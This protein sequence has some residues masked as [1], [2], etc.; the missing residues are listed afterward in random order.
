MFEQ[1]LLEQ[2]PKVFYEILIAHPKI[3][4]VDLTGFIVFRMERSDNSKIFFTTLD[5][6]SVNDLPDKAFKYRVS[7]GGFDNKTQL[8]LLKDTFFLAVVDIDIYREGLVE[9][10]VALLKEINLEPS[11]ILK[12]DKGLHIVYLSQTLLISEEELNVY[13]LYSAC[14]KFK[15][16]LKTFLGDIVPIDKVMIVDGYYTRLD[17]EVVYEGYLYENFYDWYFRFHIEREVEID[18]EEEK[19]IKPQELTETFN[20]NNLLKGSSFITNPFLPLYDVRYILNYVKFNCPTL[21]YILNNFENHT[22]YEWK[23]AIWF[24]YFLYKYIANEDEKKVLLND[25][26]N[27]ASLYRKHPP[28]KSIKY[29]QKFFEWFVMRDFP[30]LFWSCNK[31]HEVF[32]CGDCPHKGLRRLPFIPDFYLPENVIYI[33]DR[34][35]A[36]HHDK[37][38][39]SY[40]VYICQFF[41][42]L[43][44]VL[45]PYGSKEVK[46]KIITFFNKQKVELIVSPD[47]T[48]GLKEADKF[49]ISE[50]KKF[51]ELIRY[52]NSNLL[53]VM[54]QDLIGVYPTGA[55]HKYISIEDFALFTSEEHEFGNLVVE[56][57]GSYDKFEQALLTLLYDFSDE[58]YFQ[59]KIAVLLGLFS[60]F[61][62]RYYKL[63]SLNP[64]F[65]WFGTSGVGKTTCAKIV[66]A[67]FREP[68][69]MYEAGL[70]NITEAWMNR[71]APL[72]RAPLFVDDIKVQSITEFRTLFNR[73][74]QLANRNLTKLNVQFT[75]SGN[76]Y[77][78][79]FFTSELRFVYRFVATDGLNRRFFFINMGFKHLKLQDI[80]RRIAEEIISVLE[81]N[82]GHGFTFYEKFIMPY[83]NQILAFI[84]KSSNRFYEIFDIGVHNK[85]LKCLEALARIVFKD[86]EKAEG[87]IFRFFRTLINKPFK[88]LTSND[89]VGLLSLAE[90]YPYI[91]DNIFDEELILTF[92]KDFSEIRNFAEHIAIFYEILDN[93]SKICHELNLFYNLLFANVFISNNELRFMYPD[94]YYNFFYQVL[95]ENKSPEILIEQVLLVQKFLKTKI[96]VLKEVGLYDKF[97]T[98]LEKVDF[99]KG[100][101]LYELVNKFEKKFLK[102]KILKRNEEIDEEKIPF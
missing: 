53:R 16:Y 101:T 10:V 23:L 63:F 100:F 67:F 39:G 27:K 81:E 93:L 92:L 9:E 66:N 94:F 2:K 90:K 91:Y 34:Y 35:Y 69:K 79:L 87:L 26:L 46:I 59:Y 98:Y 78:L 68:T 60:I 32:N 18:I 74:Y 61:Y 52:F 8:E 72:I 64:G 88:P 99:C 76:F 75:G 95:I 24:Y 80:A 7:V 70:E 38:I 89:K 6:I 97:L 96:E 1:E 14:Y 65:M 57:K 56:K 31:M 40:Y 37:K 15:Q 12:T 82:Y 20:I 55:K 85:I 58:E 22:Y 84:E 48:K 4:K 3:K 45:L 51:L 77:W 5:M 33:D 11:C 54:E 17:A 29:T 21:N 13:A 19:A 102:E 73:M 86:N 49:M 25:L 50:K 30:M 62:L 36:I 71:K 41:Y 42:P 47:M 83:E 28:E 43:S 44:V